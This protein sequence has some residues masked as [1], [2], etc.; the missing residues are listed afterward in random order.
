MVRKVT[1]QSNPLTLVG[2]GLQKGEVVPSFKAVSLNL[3]VLD[4]PS[5]DG[6]IKIITSFP[7]LDTPVCDLQVKEFNKQAALF[8]DEASVIAVS[9]DLPFAQKRFCDL[10]T[11]SNLQVVSD[12]RFAS[13]GNNYG[14]LIKELNLLARSILIID[15]KNILR[16][17]QI[18]DELT[19]APDYHEALSVLTKLLNNINVPL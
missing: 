18:V 14:L 15:K 6:K 3:E 16:Y 10:N 17:V 8:S 2:K 11:I 12:Y 13:F 9:M 1:F 4:F 7:S 19:Q 5:E